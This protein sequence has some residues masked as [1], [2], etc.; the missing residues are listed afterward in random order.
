M[1]VP[2]DALRGQLS[3]KFLTLGCLHKFGIVTSD[4]MCPY[5]SVINTGMDIDGWKEIV[6]RSNVIISTMP[7]LSQTSEDVRKY[8]SREITNVFV[9]EAHH[10]EA[11]TWCEFLEVFPRTNIVQFTATP[12]RNDGR[13]MRGE[14]IYTFH[15]VQHRVRVIIRK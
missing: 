6:S 15:F 14:F 4:C 1:T 2:H 8:L 7:L 5:V 12:F 10:T 3:D 13:K 11:P 9:D